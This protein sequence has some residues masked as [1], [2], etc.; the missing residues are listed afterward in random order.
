MDAVTCC[1]GCITWV[2]DTL[3]GMLHCWLQMFHLHVS[4]ELTLGCCSLR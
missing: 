1:L 2:T 4:C 3:A